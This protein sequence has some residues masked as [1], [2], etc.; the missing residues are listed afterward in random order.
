LEAEEK[1]IDSQS[2]LVFYIKHLAVL[3]YYVFSDLKL[4]P[5]ILRE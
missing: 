3:P 4:N 5:I 2:I 1:E